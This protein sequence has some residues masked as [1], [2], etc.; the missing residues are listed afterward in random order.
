MREGE[1]ERE[2]CRYNAYRFLVQSVQRLEAE[3]GAG[4]AFVGSQGRQIESGNLM[5]RWIQ[6]RTPSS[7]S[8]PSQIIRVRSSESYPSRV[9]GAADDAPQRRRRE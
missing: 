4:G 5:D 7:E 6:A 2:H 3:D 1:R 9:S 8:Y